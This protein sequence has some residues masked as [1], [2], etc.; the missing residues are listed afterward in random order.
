MPRCPRRRCRGC[1][2]ARSTA[3]CGCPSPRTARA[4]CCGRSCRCAGKCTYCPSWSGQLEISVTL[5]IICLHTN[6]SHLPT[7]LGLLLAD[8]LTTILRTAADR[9]WCGCGGRRGC[10]CW[11]GGGGSPS[12]LFLFFL[13]IFRIFPYI[14]LFCATIFVPIF[15]HFFTFFSAWTFCV[16]RLPG[17]TF[18]SFLLDT[19]TTPLDSKAIPSPFCATSGF[20][21]GFFFG[22]GL[23]FGFGLWFAF[24]LGFGFGL[25]FVFLIYIRNSFYFLH[26][27]KS[28]WLH[29]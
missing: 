14:A 13:A 6:E 25:G 8:T 16:A 18:W 22:F 5:S 4:A 20:G 27:S 17:I 12:F 1:C 11:C 28:F 9:G 19:K 21:F 10:C 3:W 15:W 26:I 23:R 7:T 24:W 29:G 2:R